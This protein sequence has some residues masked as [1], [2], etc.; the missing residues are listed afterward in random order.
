MTGDF[1]GDGSSVHSTLATPFATHDLA[2]LKTLLDQIDA[3]GSKVAKTLTSGFASATASGKSLN[4]VLAQAA[5]SLAK[6]A[7]KSGAQSLTSGLGGMVSS[8]FGGA[9]G[10]DG[11]VAPFADGGVVASPTF[12]GAGSSVGL[13]GERGAEAILPLARGPNGQLGVAAQNGSKAAPVSV[14]VNIAA[15]DLESFRRSET[16]ITGAL[17]R[18]VARGQRSL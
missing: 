8:L 11:A 18:A 12:F 6:L 17:A 9:F 13:M 10:G 3:S 2:S 15:Q 7:I 4:D 16:Q 1:N 5:L 14:T